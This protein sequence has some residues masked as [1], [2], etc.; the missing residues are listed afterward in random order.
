[1]LTH[2]LVPLG[3]IGVQGSGAQWGHSGGTVADSTRPSASGQLTA[4]AVF[5]LPSLTSEPTHMA[6]KFDR[7]RAGLTDRYSMDLITCLK[8]ACECSKPRRPS[9]EDR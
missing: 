3:D 9:M 7:L 4:R 2:H 1:V 6:E 8:I 5:W